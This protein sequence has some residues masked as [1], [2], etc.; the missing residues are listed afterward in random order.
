MILLPVLVS[1]GGVHEGR[2]AVVALM[3]LASLRLV[4]VLEH[5]GLINIFNFDRFKFKFMVKLFECAVCKA[6]FRDGY[7]LRRHGSRHERGL[8]RRGKN[9]DKTCSSCNGV[10]KHGHASR[11]KCRPANGRI[12]LAITAG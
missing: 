12:D 2:V 5:V 7:N 11:H 4:L 8:T 10:I 6:N 9:Y 1:V 3:Y